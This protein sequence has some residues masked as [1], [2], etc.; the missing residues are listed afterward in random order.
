KQTDFGSLRRLAQLAA[1]VVNTKA[2]LERHATALAL[3]PDGRGAD[4][5]AD[6]LA[7]T[8]ATFETAAA[9][10][11]AMGALECAPPATEQTRVPGTVRTAARALADR[12]PGADGELAS[13]L[14]LVDAGW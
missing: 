12:A 11:S 8:A 5:P 6:A 4:T 14:A 13:A 10:R 2:R 1:S 9:V 7:Q 3:V